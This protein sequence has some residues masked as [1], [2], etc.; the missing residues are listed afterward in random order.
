[1][2]RSPATARRSAAELVAERIRLRLAQALGEEVA[3]ADLAEVERRLAG[4]EGVHR[5]RLHGLFNLSA[6]EIDCLD[7]AVAVAVEPALGPAF[8]T[9]QGQPGRFLPTMVALRLLF[10]HGPEPMLLPTGGLLAWGMVRRIPGRPGEPEMIEADPEIVEWLF[11]RLAP[12]LLAGV[13]IAAAV[14]PKPLPEWHVE[15]H[16]ERIRRILAAGEPVRVTIS[17]L[18]GTGRSSLAAAI[19]DALGAKAMLAEAVVP[20]ADFRPVFQRLQR[21]ALLGDLALIWRGDPGTWPSDVPVAPL[22]FV[23]VE[24]DQ[25]PQRRRGLVDFVIPMPEL[26]RESLKRLNARYLPHLKDALSPLG[27]P[28]LCDLSDAAA[29]QMRNAGEFRDMLRQRT[30]ERTGGI[31]RIAD[32]AF[33][34]NDLVLPDRTT[35]LL[36]SVEQEALLRHA[37]LKDAE[38]GRLFGRT[39]QLTV[40][41]SGPP[42]T[43]KS[44]SGQVLARTLGLDLMHIDMA[45]TI[46][47]FVGETA[48]NLSA[49]FRAARDAH[50]A[51]MF[52][53]ADSLFARRTDTDSVNA[54]HANADTG[55][56]LQLIEGHDGLVMLSTNRRANIDSAFLR[57][58]RFIIEFP[59][60]GVEQRAL[61]WDKLL[62]PLGVAKKARQAMVPRLAATH[63][64]SPA[65]IKG[66]ALSAAYLAE[67]AGKPIGLDHLTDGVMREFGK[68]G[69]LA[70]VVPPAAAIARRTFHA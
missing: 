29:Q 52:E 35:A 10:G 48:K 62:A 22:Q 25:G 33:T 20:P 23:T 30:R 18:D 69:R 21:T 40:L 70:T 44:M 19:V 16:A 63:E 8:A 15:T 58:M 51:M 57:R 31:G 43:G 41:M 12:E 68:E 14:A 32:L 42:G 3:E 4:P 65:Q 9:L 49:A 50:C 6:A 59:M 36:K 55:H 53:E 46:S 60:P 5:A 45:T 7:C 47:K 56:L 13:T 37:L 1:M 26:S 11:G 38:K 27:T 64:L 34:W 28:R 67:A 39:A 2:A 24:P 54:R 17:G 61:L 66:A